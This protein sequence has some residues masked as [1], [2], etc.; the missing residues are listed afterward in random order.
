MIELIYNI[1]E[2]NKGCLFI[3]AAALLFSTKFMFNESVKEIAAAAIGLYFSLFY[4][5][6]KQQKRLLQ[7]LIV[8]P[9]EALFS[10]HSD[11]QALCIFYNMELQ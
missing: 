1:N 9:Q 6:L 10:V 5:I 2:G 3:S 7:Q 8:L 11:Y 4:G